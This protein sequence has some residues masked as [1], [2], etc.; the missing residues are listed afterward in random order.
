[1]PD[2]CLI[3][4][5]KS[6]GLLQDYDALINFLKPW[7]GVNRHASKILACLKF[8]SVFLP[9]ETE[10]DNS[11][12]VLPSKAKQKAMLKTLRESK[13]LGDLDNPAVAKASWMTALR[14]QW[15]LERGKPSAEIKARL[16]KAAM[17]A[18]KEKEKQNKA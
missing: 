8:S 9:G 4:L 7:C 12:P 15:L 2:N 1:M 18:K 11:K 6:G 14:D 5:S 13:K 3:A 16:K 17:A 10:T